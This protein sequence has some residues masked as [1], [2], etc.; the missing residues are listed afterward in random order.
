MYNLVCTDLKSPTPL[1]NIYIEIKFE[2]DKH[3]VI[4]PND[5]I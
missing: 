4:N 1:K 5:L 3:L 2:E